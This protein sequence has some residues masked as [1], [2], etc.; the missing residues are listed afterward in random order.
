MAPLPINVGDPSYDPLYPFGWGL[1]TDPARPRLVA[2]RDALAAALRARPDA[3]LALGLVT[4]DLALLPTAWR[5]DGSVRD[6]GWV[7]GWLEF[8]TAQLERSR[9]DVSRQFDPIV[10]V[11]RDVAQARGGVSAKRIADGEHLLLTGDP[12]GAIGLLTP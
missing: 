10:S 11:A 8:A 12:S 6:A 9:V 7:L 2:A 5:P 3:R 4:V 1:R